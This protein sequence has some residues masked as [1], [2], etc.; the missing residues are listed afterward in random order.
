MYSPNLYPGPLFFGLLLT[1]WTSAAIA[2]PE[3][4]YRRGLRAFTE[5]DLIVAMEVLGQASDAGHSQA[6]ALLGYIFDKAEEL[7]FTPPI[8]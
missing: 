4:D 3:A 7:L 2:D 8:F 1:L 5:D 6:Q